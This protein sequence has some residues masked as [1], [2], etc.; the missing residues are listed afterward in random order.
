[1]SAYLFMFVCRTVHG[2][3]VSTC[4]H[5]QRSSPARRPGQRYGRRLCNQRVI[6]QFLQTAG[7]TL[8]ADEHSWLSEY[9]S[10]LFPS[11]VE[12]VQYYEPVTSDCNSEV[13]ILIAIDYICNSVPCI[14][15][16]NNIP[17]MRIL[18]A[19]QVLVQ[20]FPV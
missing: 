3:A 6:I 11:Y 10:Y 12:V 20:K 9:P 8:N 2:D 1:M 7:M 17:H 19:R 15:F 18:L 16:V 5:M 14:F 4:S 13:Y